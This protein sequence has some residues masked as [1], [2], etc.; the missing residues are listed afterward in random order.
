MSSPLSH[1]RVL[2]LSRHLAGPWAAQMLADLGADVIKV[3]RPKVGDDMRHFGPPFAKGPDGQETKESPFFLAANRGKRSVTIDIASKE[4][5]ALIRR[6][7][8]HCDVVIENYR[9]GT[10]TRYGLGY[11][12]LKAIKPDL[13]YCS[14]TGFGQAGPYKD[15]AGYDAIF[16]AMSG[17]MSVT[18]VP[19]GEAG[20]GPL[21]TGMA[22]SDMSAGLYSSIAL[23]AALMHRERT[24]V[25]QHLDMA[26]LDT[27]MALLAVE[28]MRHLLLGEVPQRLGH[29][30]RN[31]VPAQQFEC[32]DGYLILSVGTN[33]QFQKLMVIMGQPEL[34]TD[35]RFA[36]NTAR[37]KHRDVLLP[38]LE[39]LFRTQPV[40]HWISQLGAAAIPSAPVNHIGQVFQDP[41]VQQ[42]GMRKEIDHPTVGRMPL[43]GNPIKFSVTPVQYRRAPPTLGQHTAEVLR[44]FAGAD[45]AQLQ[46]LADKEVI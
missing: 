30:S 23:L 20:G 22:V 3:E 34:G 41:H 24:G 40:A 7:V 42:R 31:M 33:D 1:I 36:T 38:L 5:Q 14:V 12:D 37:R 39:Q 19:D 46:A 29:V 6:M 16:Q 32:A 21:K 43:L 11:D 44:E 18:G 27:S 45:D 26:L 28:N 4:G 8:Q 9:V 10:L 35:E 17:I 2:D 25:G 13:V 15:H